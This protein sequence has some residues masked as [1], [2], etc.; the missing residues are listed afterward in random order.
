MLTVLVANTKGGC[1]KTTIATNLAAAFA[2]G[3]LPTALA[4]VDRQKSSLGWLDRRPADQPPIA[5][6]DWT[7]APDDAPGGIDR[8]VIDAPAAM[9]IKTAEALIARADVIVLPVLP[10]R[11]D[12][13]ATARFVERIDALKPI[14]KRRKG[15]AVVGNRLRPRSR[16]AARLDGFLA[17]L[18]HGVAA[19]LRDSALYADAAEDG[20]GVFDLG[21]RRTAGLRED[22]TPLVTAIE[23]A[24]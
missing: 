18:G 15:V 12:E 8:L 14:R 16:A 7:K 9:K 6:L 22:W 24:E 4:D 20:L 3:G 10:S 21:A 13:A 1:G 11:F 23:T 5:G 17:D 2:R 19:R